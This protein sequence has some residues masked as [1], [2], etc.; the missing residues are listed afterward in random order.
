MKHP[1]RNRRHYPGVSMYP[2][3]T[4]FGDQLAELP[5]NLDEQLNHHHEWAVETLS[6]EGITYE[7][8]ARVAL[9]EHDVRRDGQLIRERSWRI[10]GGN[11]LELRDRRFHDTALSAPACHAVDVVYHGAMLRELVANH[12]GSEAAAR[13]LAVLAMSYGYA[14]REAAIT[15]GLDRLDHD[16]PANAQAARRAPGERRRK[17]LKQIAWEHGYNAPITRR[18]RD[19]LIEL[20]RNG[21]GKGDKVTDRRL[22]DQVR[23]LGYRVKPGRTP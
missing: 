2:G 22:R 6:Q 4:A 7:P 1:A 23:D 15:L 12:D 18:E 13:R 16:R 3:V 14:V 21:P 9:V 11:L 10:E 17:A 5:V 19:E 20:Y 8:P